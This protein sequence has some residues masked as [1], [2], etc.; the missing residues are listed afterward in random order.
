MS[1]SKYRPE[2]DGLRYIAVM[3][4]ILYHAGLP[5]LRGGFVGVD[6]FLVIS[7]YLI[8]KIVYAELLSR[9]F[10]FAKFYERRV[11][12]I[13]LALALM[14]MVMVTTAAGW[15]LQNLPA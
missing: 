11:R 10:S 7:G 4:V 5:W 12:R 3:S 1:D 15:V 13:F 14:L 9:Q 6:V 2:V 8:T